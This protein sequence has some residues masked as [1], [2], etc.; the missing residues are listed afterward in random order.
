MFPGLMTGSIY[1]DADLLV[2][3]FKGEGVTDGSVVVV[4]THEWGP[5]AR[6]NYSGAILLV[7]DPLDCIL[8]EFNRERGG[9]HTG[10]AGMDNFKGEGAKRWKGFLK[11][12]LVKWEAMNIDWINN[13]QGHLLV[14]SYNEVL[15]DLEKELEKILRFLGLSVDK[16]ELDCALSKQEGIYKRSE[17][18]VLHLLDGPLAKIVDRS[19]KTVLKSLNYDFQI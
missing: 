3:G 8:S 17:R 5:S 18:R 7:R 16:R 19:K 14:I 2:N 9:G 13:F 1:R 10:H 15:K 6:S 12:K 11:K 4:K